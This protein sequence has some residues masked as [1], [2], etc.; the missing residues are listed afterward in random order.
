MSF[1]CVC[2]CVCVR[3]RVCVCVCVCV[4]V[5][6]CDPERATGPS[7][8]TFLHNTQRRTAVDRTPL[9]E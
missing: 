5:W 7:F 1:V 9:E 2:V 6:H 8:L 3:V 4:C